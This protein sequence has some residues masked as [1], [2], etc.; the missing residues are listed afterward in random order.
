[1]KDSKIEWT[2]HTA[3][4]W[5][6][7]TKVHEGCDNCYAEGI[8]KRWGYDVWGQDKHRKENKTVWKQL[9][10]FQRLAAASG[11]IHRVFVGSMMDMF[12]RPMPLIDYNR[13]PLPYTTEVLRQRFFELVPQY[14][15]LLF[16]FLTKRPSNIH[17]Y[18]PHSWLQ[19]PPDNIM[20]GTS[21]VSQLT[22][23][24]LIPQLA[25]VKGKRFISVEPQLEAVDLM[26]L[27]ADGRKL[28]DCVDWVIV[29]GESGSRKRP[30]DLEWGRQIRE[31]CKT[32]G[33]PFFFKQVDKVQAIPE[34]LQIREFPDFAN[35]IL[36]KAG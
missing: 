20:Y 23:D 13:N 1:M 12:E 29:G 8:A 30:Y 21:P 7:C 5:N 22:A 33:K 10:K 17:K 24:R 14:H 27:N 3:N 19:N 6:G 18:I 25:N 11:E 2:K 34:D 36:V 4:L 16:L 26:K 35:S 28:I 9:D 31:A 32:S 15:N